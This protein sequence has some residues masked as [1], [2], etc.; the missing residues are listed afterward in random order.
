[1]RTAEKEFEIWIEGYAATGEH[2]P[3]SYVGKS[4]GETFEDAVINFRYPEDVKREWAMP[5]ED[6]ILIHKGSPLNLDKDD[7]QP[8]GYRRYAGKICSWAC[9]YF[10]NEADARKSFG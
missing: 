9:R 8:D 5:N 10:D 3:A 6:P 2:S 4:R 1:M 7:K